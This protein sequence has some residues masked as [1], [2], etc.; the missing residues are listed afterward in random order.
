MAAPQYY[1]G[2]RLFY[3]ANYLRWLPSDRQTRVVNIGCGLGH[4]VYFLQ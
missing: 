1:A 4:F 2:L 3:W